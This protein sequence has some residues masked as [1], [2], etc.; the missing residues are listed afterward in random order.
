MGLQGLS[1]S[2][3]GLTSHF[4]SPAFVTCHTGLTSVPQWLGF[5]LLRSLGRCCS[6]CFD[7]QHPSPVTSFF[8]QS[9]FN[10][11]LFRNILLSPPPRRSVPLAHALT[12]PVPLRALNTA[13]V[14]I[15]MCFPLMN[16]SL[17][18][19][20]IGFMRAGLSQCLFFPCSFSYCCALSA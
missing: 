20:T 7:P 1:A 15:Y 2:Y 10:C 19:C 18:S 6:L 3:R 11:N 9:Q 16:V 5:F 4:T 13:L 17:R 14:E 12:V 8:L